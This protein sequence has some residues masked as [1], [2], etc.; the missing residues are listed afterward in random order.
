MNANFTDPAPIT[1]AYYARGASSP[2]T[3]VTETL[4]PHESRLHYLPNERLPV[5]FTGAAIVTSTGGQIVGVAKS[6][7]SARAP[8]TGS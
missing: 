5:G 1:I 4:A 3:T 2:V 7:R 8:E 6:W